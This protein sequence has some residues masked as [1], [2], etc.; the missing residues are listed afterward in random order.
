M[1]PGDS[2]TVMVTYLLNIPK[3]EEGFS[4]TAAGSLSVHNWKCRREMTLGD[5]LISEHVVK[6][7]EKVRKETAA[8]FT[9]RLVE[10][11]NQ[12]VGPGIYTQEAGLG[13]SVFS[14]CIHTFITI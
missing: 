14:T 4:M 11:I 12:Y 6:V 13:V 1:V 8:S 3:G 10:K 5:E 7:E 2:E 9:A